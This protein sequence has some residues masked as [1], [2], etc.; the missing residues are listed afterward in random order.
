MFRFHCAS[1][2]VVVF[3]FHVFFKV[4]VMEFLGENDPI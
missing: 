4:F 3:L 1:F 2:K